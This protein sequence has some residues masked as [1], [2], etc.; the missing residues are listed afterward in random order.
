MNGEPRA[1]PGPILRENEATASGKLFKHVL[2]PPGPVFAP[3][4]AAKLSQRDP[5]QKIIL[6]QRACEMASQIGISKLHVKFEF[7]IGISN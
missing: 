3:K 2:G 1:R 5:N 4:T 7:K 6:L